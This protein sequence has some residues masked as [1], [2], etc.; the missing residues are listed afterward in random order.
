MIDLHIHSTASDGTLSPMEIVK[1]A[2][3][4]AINAIA[5]TDHDTIDG[6]RELIES[7]IPPC[8]ELVTGLEISATPPPG[9]EINDSLHILGYGISIYDQNLNQTL[10]RLKQVRADRNPEI[11]RRLNRLGF[12]ITLEE[13]EEICGPGQTG[14]PHI[15]RAMVNRGFVESFDQAFDLFLG[16]GKPAYVDKERLTSQE[17]ITLI[18]EAGGV[19]VLAHPGLIELG[20]NSSIKPLVTALMDMGLLGIEVYHTDHSEEQTDYFATLAFQKGLIITG[21]SD[22]HGDLKQGTVMGRGEGD[23]YVDDELYRILVRKIEALQDA[24]LRLEILENNLGHSFSNRELLEN[25]LRHSSYVNELQINPVPDNQRLEFLG[26]AVLGLTIGH[27]LMEESPEMNEGN[28]SK[29]RASLVSEPGLASMARHIDLGRF[30]RLGKGERLSRGS[31]KNSILADTFEAVIA[32]VYL[33][34]GF[35]KT[36]TLIKGQFISQIKMVNTTP[37]TEDFKSRLQEFVQERG[38]PSP[39]Y[40]I[41]GQFGPDHDKTFSICVKAGK[42]ESMG[43]G[44]SKKAAEQNAAHNALLILKESK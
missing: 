27:L 5:I 12:K 15:A 41:H 13:V 10:E 40:A 35:D 31:E 3:D 36:Y 25:A 8:L 9:F 34:C 4:S 17:A 7:G 1:T 29:A 19:P 11:I 28:L 20:A 21:G 2:V 32:A 6:V 22:F 39:C 30:I 16:T 42:I 24:N 37:E 33:D 38:N 43:S 18:L 44:K 14:R 23:L 26:D